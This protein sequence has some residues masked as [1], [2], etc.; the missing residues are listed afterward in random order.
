MP[1]VDALSAGAQVVLAGP[2]PLGGALVE[3]TAL[4]AR[5]LAAPDLRIVRAAAGWASPLRSAGPW[6][7]WAQSARSARLAA[8]QA[9]RDWDSELL[10]EPRPTREQLFGRP[11]V[12]GGAGPLQP[13][14][15]G[16]EPFGAAG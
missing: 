6:A 7:A 1:V 4:I 12:D 13:V 11:A 2:A 16:R 8:E 5:W 14:L 3:E 10:G 15:P 9:V